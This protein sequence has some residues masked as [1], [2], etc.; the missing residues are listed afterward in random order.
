MEPNYTPDRFEEF[1]RKSLQDFEENPPAEAWQNIHGRVPV[2]SPRIGDKRK[3]LA[4]AASVCLLLSAFGAQFYYF[5]QKLAQAQ[6]ELTA[7]KAEIERISATLNQKNIESATILAQFDAVQ[8]ETSDVNAQSTARPLVHHTKSEGTFTPKTKAAQ[9]TASSLSEPMRILTAKS[10]ND[11]QNTQN[12]LITKEKPFANIAETVQ[13]DQQIKSQEAPQAPFREESIRDEKPQI[14]L[15]TNAL[16]LLEGYVT[17]LKLA[18]QAIQA[19]RLTAPYIPVQKSRSTLAIRAYTIAGRTEQEVLLRGNPQNGPKD[20]VKQDY[21]QSGTVLQTGIQVEKQ[22]TR[23]VVLFGGLAATQ[24]TQ[25]G[26]HS[27]KLK[28]KHGGGGHGGP[29]QHDSLT[30]DYTIQT[31]T[32]VVDVELRAVDTTSMMHND[33]VDIMLKTIEKSRYTSVPVGVKLLLLQ[34]GRL[35]LALGAGV[36]LNLPTKRDIQIENVDFMAPFYVKPD[37]RDRN[38]AKVRTQGPDPM[39]LWWNG[40]AHIAYALSPR[41]KI[42][43]APTIFRKANRSLENGWADHSLSGTSVQFGLSYRL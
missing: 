39:D 2:P 8:S 26:Q 4:I 6:M 5:N 16:S 19:P 38:R 34:K 35:S 22:I 1:L 9:P 10:Q 29:N 14:S 37:P 18:S 24:V 12:Q 32:G 7:Q 33:D 11:T 23:R 21:N 40:S 36:T 43:V 42:D 3:V 15:Q 25:Q 13:T 27:I 41:M 17:Q 31:S 20:F 28:P 30:F